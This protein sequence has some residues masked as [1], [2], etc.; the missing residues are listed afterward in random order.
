[1]SLSELPDDHP[2]YIDGYGPSTVGEVRGEC[3]PDDTDS[4]TVRMWV[5]IALWNP[6]AKPW[7][8][9]HIDV[10]ARRVHLSE[11]MSDR[12]VRLSTSSGTTR[13]NAYSDPSRPS[14][15]TRSQTNA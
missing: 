9:G 2:I 15:A 4:A 14:P 12:V 7:R 13:E 6:R 1:M 11:L 10:G 5:A 8:D 3:L